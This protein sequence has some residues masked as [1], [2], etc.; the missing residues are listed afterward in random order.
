MAGNGLRATEKAVAQALLQVDAGQAGAQ[1]EI[2]DAVA[3]VV[4]GL[5]GVLAVTGQACCRLR[6]VAVIRST[7]ASTTR[8]REGT[9]YPL[10]VS[11]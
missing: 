4:Q 10:M 9:L 11:M 6:C 7:N 2:Q 8:D 3:V 5:E 1:G